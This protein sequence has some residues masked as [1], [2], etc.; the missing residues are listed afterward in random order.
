MQHRDKEK[1]R[2]YMTLCDSRDNEDVKSK[3]QTAVDDKSRPLG[4][5]LR[6]ALTREKLDA[7]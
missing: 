2:R 6:P 4:L 3:T 7:V 5:P 1:K